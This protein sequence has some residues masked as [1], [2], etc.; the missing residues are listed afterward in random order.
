MFWEYHLNPRPGEVYNAGG[1]RFSNCSM[2]E[3]IQIAEEVTGRTLS[4]TQAE[5]NRIGDHIWY[6]SDTRK[7]RSHYPQCQQL[8]GIH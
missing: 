1:G 3:A 2:R 5:Q 4:F 7:F 8:Y 6:V